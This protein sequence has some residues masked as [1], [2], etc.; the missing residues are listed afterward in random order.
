MAPWFP[1]LIT[2]LPKADLPVA[3]ITGW[4]LQGETRQAVFFEIPP[5]A[6]VPEH[7]HG[8][9]WGVVLDGEIE[10]TIGGETRVYRK[11]D[12]YEIPAGAVHGAR[13]PAGARVLA[14]FA[15]VSRYQPRG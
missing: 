3:G 11:G 15:D 14:L 8:A 6:E 9:Q 7:S 4:L 13:C 12:A 5:G 10:L 1:D 2:T